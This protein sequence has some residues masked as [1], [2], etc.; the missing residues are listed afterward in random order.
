MQYIITKKS[1]AEDRLRNGE[2]VVPVGRPFPF[3]GKI[4]DLRELFPDR[5]IEVFKEDAVG[6][7][8]GDNDT[9]GEPGEGSA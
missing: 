5:E 9:G 8:D 4:S 7:V 1:Y 6:E 3:E 2:V